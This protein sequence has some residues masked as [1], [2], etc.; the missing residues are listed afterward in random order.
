MESRTEIGSPSCRSW[1]ADDGSLNRG[2]SSGRRRYSSGRY[3]RGVVRLHGCR[4]HRRRTTCHRPRLCRPGSHRDRQVSLDET[5]R[6]SILRPFGSVA[7]IAAVPHCNGRGTPHPREDRSAQTPPQ[8]TLGGLEPTAA[9]REKGW[10]RRSTIQ[11]GPSTLPQGLPLDDLGGDPSAGSPT[12]TLFTC[13]PCRQG[14]W[15]VSSSD[16]ALRRSLACS[17]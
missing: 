13:S 2:L 11:G 10:I 12:D 9:G 4:W 3:H 8:L 6:P 7:G 14:A 15:T 17:L 16:A 5:I 1:A